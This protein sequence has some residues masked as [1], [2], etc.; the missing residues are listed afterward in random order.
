M[1]T[2]HF[3]RLRH[4]DRFITSIMEMYFFDNVEWVNI[5]FSYVIIYYCL[6]VL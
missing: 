1:K 6:T 2:N 3:M 5:T 4:N